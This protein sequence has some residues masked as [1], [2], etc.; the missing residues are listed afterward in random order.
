[1]I[2]CTH[3]LARAV[4][5]VENIDSWVW[6]FPELQKWLALD[7]GNGVTVIFDEHHVICNHNV[8][9]H[10]YIVNIGN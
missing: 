4:V 1:M 2:R 9:V 3:L 7:K 10:L 5:E 8:C 6:F